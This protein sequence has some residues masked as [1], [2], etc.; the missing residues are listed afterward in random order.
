MFLLVDCV[1]IIII[2]IRRRGTNEA[3]EIN[4]RKSRRKEE[5]C[6][7]Y[8][9][10]PKADLDSIGCA[11]K[12]A[13]GANV[14]ARRKQ[15]RIS[16][17]KKYKKRRCMMHECDLFAT[18][19]HKPSAKANQ[20]TANAKCIKTKAPNWKIK[21]NWGEHVERWTFLQLRWN[22]FLRH[23]QGEYKI[24][25]IYT[26]EKQM[27]TTTAKKKILFAVIGRN[28]VIFLGKFHVKWDVSECMMAV[29]TLKWIKVF[30]TLYV[31]SEAE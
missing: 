3:T 28:F 19:N 29:W 11:L 9:T 5:K 12:L 26:D 21:W 4:Q 14:S 25:D 24:Q 6:W 31:I 15:M 23:A 1:L 22:S 2:N 30:H 17:Q 10:F 27:A 18:M 8:F 7:M 13:N 16:R 20:S